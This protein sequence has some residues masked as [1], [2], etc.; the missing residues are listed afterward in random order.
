MLP[1]DQD[2]TFRDPYDGHHDA[3]QRGSSA[4]LLEESLP[5]TGESPPVGGGRSTMSRT[6]GGGLDTLMREC[7]LPPEDPWLR[8]PHGFLVK[9]DFKRH[10]Q[11]RSH[12]ER[13]DAVV[14]SQRRGSKE[15]ASN[16]GVL[17]SVIGM[18]SRGGF[19]RRYFR[20]EKNELSYYRGLTDKARL[21]AVNL[22]DV[23]DVRLSRV[24]DAPSHALDLVAAD[25]VFTVGA[26][27][28]AELAR[29]ALAI[30]SRIAE[31]ETADA[32]ASNQHVACWKPLD[33]RYERP[34]DL[35]LRLARA[36]GAEENGWEHGFAVVLEC[37]GAAENRRGG[38]RA[39]DVLVGVNDECF[40]GYD[41]ALEAL[42]AAAFPCT[43]RLLRDVG[44]S[45]VI[46]EGWAFVD[47]RYRYAELTRAELV[48]T[49]PA[50]GRRLAPR[51]DRAINLAAV[52]TLVTRS[53]D[54]E[55]TWEVLVELNGDPN[56][57][58]AL[59][60]ASAGDRDAWTEAISAARAPTPIGVRDAPRAETLEATSPYG[61]M[62]GGD[63]GGG[64]DALA[65]HDE[66]P[67]PPGAGG[68]GE[69]PPRRRGWVALGGRRVFGVLAEGRRRLYYFDEEPEG[70][71]A[72]PAGRV[73]LDGARPS[74]RSNPAALELL[75]EDTTKPPLSVEPERDA[76][77]WHTLVADL[78][79]ADTSK[80][81]PA[82][83]LELRASRDDV[84]ILLGDLRFC[85]IVKQGGETFAGKWAH[86]YGAI[87]RDELR[88]YSYSRPNLSM[89]KS[90]LALGRLLSAKPL[91]E[92]PHRF[93]LEIADV[94]A[95][96]GKVAFRFEAPTVSAAESFVQRITTAAELALQ[97]PT[98]PADAAY[99]QSGWAAPDQAAT[100]HSPK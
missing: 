36:V 60:L 61:P 91:A 33:D 27:T 77:L 22:R 32:L 5:V 51:Q 18:A 35:S 83:A 16:A 67:P 44:K 6:R 95:P 65:P 66:P 69:P 52:S 90:P 34:C 71:E 21:G 89:V 88:L 25:R 9:P 93:E 1:P 68:A 59:R 40:E 64:A 62:V 48:A 92:T 63:D 49:R 13:D 11:S 45:H 72:A 54:D 100:L 79:D 10:E 43:L 14:G 75:F 94:T 74:L 41:A 7:G 50:P 81:F 17:A 53:D 87:E 19:H 2:Q 70:D 56:D 47:G 20:L 46:C 37:A 76:H 58:V 38:V 31:L 39:G 78:A 73:E 96:S 42:A 80:R 85:M 8:E 97:K 98:V 4:G 84:L 29:W 99:Q 28:R 3:R 12:Y 82:L 26:D 57:V 86:C 55:G 24:E 30:C 15:Q 23:E